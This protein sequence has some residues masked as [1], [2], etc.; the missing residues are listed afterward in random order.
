MLAFFPTIWV[1]RQQRFHRFQGHSG[2]QPAFRPH[3]RGAA[4]DYRAALR[5]ATWPAAPLSTRAPGGCCAPSAMPRAGRI[6]GYPW[7]PLSFGSSCFQPSS[8]ASPAPVL[9][10]I[11]II[12]PSEFAPINSIE[13]VIWGGRRPWYALRAI[14][15]AVLVTTRKPILPCVPEIWLYALGALFVLVTIF[16]PRG[17]IGL[18]PALEKSKRLRISRQRRRSG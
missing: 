11:G 17:V 12:N 13:V 9:P 10:Q 15:G 14:A 18:I 5:P 7:N 8:P 2:F 4:G 6:L 1:R 3:S 16:L